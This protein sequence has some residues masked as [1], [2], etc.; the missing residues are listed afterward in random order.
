[1]DFDPEG[2]ILE[3]GLCEPCDD[4]DHNILG[5]CT[6]EECDCQVCGTPAAEEG[7]W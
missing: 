6:N 4:D 7:G 3:N 2:P 5:Q 1:M